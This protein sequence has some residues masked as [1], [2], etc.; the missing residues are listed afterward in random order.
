MFLRDVEHYQKIRDAKLNDVKETSN[1]LMALSEAW[2]SFKASGEAEFNDFAE[3][4]N[5]GALPWGI[6]PRQAADRASKPH[7]YNKAIELMSSLEYV[8]PSDPIEFAFHLFVLQLHYE[9]TYKFPPT[10]VDMCIDISFS[11]LK[12]IACRQCALIR[13][14][15]LRETTRIKKSAKGKE[16]KSQEKQDWVCKI[17]YSD[18]TKAG[19][20]LHG[21]AK[22]IH[23]E[24][25]KLQERGSIPRSVKRPSTDQIKRYLMADKKISKHFRQKGRNWILQ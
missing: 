17:Y 6:M 25:G 23:K 4:V 22:A 21:A 2:A 20:T 10:V 1:E 12:G 16:S 8:P 18:V 9:Q 5:T 11:K 24:F 3:L 7:E 14:H 13:V 15:E 19:M